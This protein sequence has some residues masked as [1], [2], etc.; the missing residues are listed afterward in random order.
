MKRLGL[1]VVC[2]G[3][4]YVSGCAHYT[5]VAPGRQNVAACCSLSTPIA[6]SRA[7]QGNVDV[8][9]VDGPLLEALY[10]FKGIADG[11]PLFQVSGAKV[12]LPVF[13]KTMVASEIMEFVVD[14]MEGAAQ[15]GLR[16]ST[17]MGV[18]V[19]AAGLKPFKIGG[20]DYG[21]QFGLLYQS[22]EGLEYEGLVVGIVMKEKLYLVAYAGTRQYYFAKYRPQVEEIMGSLKIE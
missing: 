13:K 21:F 6:W 12:T 4:L 22:R 18:D 20:F 14:S 5:L 19:A 11:Q 9:T 3:L 17:L 2:L 16:G 1:F 15:Q 10:F 7:G 8:W